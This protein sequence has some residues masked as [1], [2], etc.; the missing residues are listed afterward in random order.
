MPIEF[1]REISWKMA[2]WKTEKEL[3]DNFKMKQRKV[4]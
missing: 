4:G 2:T 1:D 3:E